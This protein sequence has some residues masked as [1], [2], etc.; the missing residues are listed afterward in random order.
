MTINSPVPMSRFQDGPRA[1]SGTLDAAIDSRG[2]ELT[3]TV[4]GPG[5]VEHQ[6]RTDMPYATGYSVRFDGVKVYLYKRAGG[7][8]QLGSAA[9]GYG[10]FVFTLNGSSLTVKDSAGR[11]LISV[12]DSS[13]PTGLRTRYT[14]SGGARITTAG[15]LL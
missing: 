8:V 5:S 13:T 15:R 7:K 1:T 3:Y 14:V 11:T 2:Y 12:N 10:T 9:A 4:V 6:V